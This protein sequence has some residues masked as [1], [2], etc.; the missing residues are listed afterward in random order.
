VLSS[1]KYLSRAH[2]VAPNIIVGCV[3]GDAVVRVSYLTK[4]GGWALV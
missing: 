2:S 4:F 1:E 3:Y